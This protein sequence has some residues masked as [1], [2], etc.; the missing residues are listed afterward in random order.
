MNRH[1]GTALAGAALVAGVLMVSGCAD[2]SEAQGVTPKRAEETTTTSMVDAAIAAIE[3]SLIDH[4]DLVN[5]SVGCLGADGSPQA[6]VHAWQNMR[7]VWLISGSEPL[8]VADALVQTNEKAGWTTPVMG[9]ETGEKPG[10]VAR[11]VVL[12]PAGDTGNAPALRISIGSNPA[13]P[14]VLYLSS[15]SPCFDGTT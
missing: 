14:P 11:T 4:V 12:V 6:S 7:Y 15:T 9:N 10:G 3:P 8:D 13:L 5:A 1:G 2:D